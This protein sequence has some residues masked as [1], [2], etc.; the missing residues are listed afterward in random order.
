MTEETTTQGKSR[1]PGKF[2]V[3]EVQSDW[4]TKAIG[5]SVEITLQS[6]PVLHGRLLDHDIYCLSLD[7]AGQKVATLVYKQGIAFIRLQNS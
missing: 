3:H 5:K 4:L 1:A 2:R 7:E 6:G